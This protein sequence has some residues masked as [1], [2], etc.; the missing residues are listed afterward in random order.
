MHIREL[1][2]LVDTVAPFRLQEEYDNAGLIVGS[3]DDDVRGVL[4]CLDVTHETVEEA[5]RVGAN[6]ILSHH[7][8]VFR[9]IRK[10]DS[11]QHS[12]LLAAI[13]M[14]IALMAAHTNF[15]AA[16]DGLNAYVARRMGLTDLQV[17][18][19]HETERSYKVVTFVPPEFRG[20]V[21]EAMFAAGAGHTGSYSHTSFRASGTGGFVPDPGTH[22]FIGEEGA[23]TSVEEDRVETI[24]SGRDLASVVK[25]LC[26]AHPY[27]EP[28]VDVFE[29]HVPGRPSA[30]FGHLGTLPH[31]MGPGEF[32]MFIKSFFG[33][34]TLPVAG[35]LPEAIERVAV[36]TGSGSSVLAAATGSGAQVLITG[37]VTYHTALDASQCGNCVVIVDHYSSERFFAAAMEQAL[38]TAARDRELPPLYRSTADYQ[39]VRFW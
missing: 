35:T 14:D 33:L 38:Q 2:D 39:P 8:P 12:A 23:M 26:A 3:M 20:Q 25:A 6:I 11:V 27:E 15:D 28:A 4:L 21:L 13:R 31:A 30:G 7:P 32:V 34:S 1:Y 9:A 37:D 16:P 24:V 22:P 19:V 29:E 18:D 5:G 36:C 10:L 17:L